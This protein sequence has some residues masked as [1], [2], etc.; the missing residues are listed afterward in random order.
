[1]IGMAYLDMFLFWSEFH[2]DLKDQSMAVSA[3]HFDSKCCA[4]LPNLRLIYACV[5]GLS[6][7]EINHLEGPF[8]VRI[9]IKNIHYTV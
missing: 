8:D 3:D 1:M 7:Q 9:C 5:F 4:L 6:Q 2:C